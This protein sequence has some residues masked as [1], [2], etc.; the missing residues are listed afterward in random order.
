MEKFKCNDWR[1]DGHVDFRIILRVEMSSERSASMFEY[2]YPCSECGL[3]YASKCLGIFFEENS[4]RVLYW[5]D[6]KK[7]FL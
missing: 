5:K 6:G 4:S 7:V 1:C 3:L 2:A